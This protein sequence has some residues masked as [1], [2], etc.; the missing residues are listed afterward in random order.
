M[1]V[2]SETVVTH[3][4]YKMCVLLHCSQQFVVYCK[5]GHSDWVS[6]VRLGEG[7]M[8]LFGNNTIYLFFKFIYLLHTT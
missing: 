5:C 7:L 2:L 1:S 4:E 3:Q 8:C 6:R